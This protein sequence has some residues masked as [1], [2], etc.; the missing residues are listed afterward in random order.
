M[1]SILTLFACN[2][3]TTSSDST[4]H[5]SVFHGDS[6]STSTD[7]DPTVYDSDSTPEDTD[8]HGSSNTPGPVVD[9]EFIEPDDQAHEI[10]SSEEVLYL[11]S[12]DEDHDS[13]LMLRLTLS[14]VDGV[15]PKVFV[16]DAEGV[17]QLTGLD[18]SES[19]PDA[20]E[21]TFSL[22]SNIYATNDPAVFLFQYV[23]GADALADDSPWEFQLYIVVQEE[24]GNFGDAEM[25]T[26]RNQL[27]AR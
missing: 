15:V 22:S 12:L 27:E 19:F 6:G 7:S 3:K 16:G 17:N 11:S 14:E 4:T 21:S 18:T 26:Y 25:I 2:G 24:N 23:P 20:E 5:D 8:N 9:V 1:L 10:R 13:A